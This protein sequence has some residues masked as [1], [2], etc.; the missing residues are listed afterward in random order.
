MRRTTALETVFRGRTGIQTL[1]HRLPGM[2]TLGEPSCASL[3]S[4][5]NNRE[6]SKSTSHLIAM[7]IQ[8][9]R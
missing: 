7:R 9:S 8:C 1:S 4:S 6:C 5:I 3:S 2:E